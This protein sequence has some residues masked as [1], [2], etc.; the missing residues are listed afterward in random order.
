MNYVGVVLAILSI[1]AFVLVRPDTEKFFKNAPSDETQNKLDENLCLNTDK[2]KTN[3]LNNTNFFD[4]LNPTVKRIVGISLAIISGIFFGSVS[5]TTL[6]IMI[7]VENASKSGSDYTFS[8]FSGILLSSIFC[9]I[10]YS[11]IKKCKPI[12]YPK[13]VVPSFSGGLIW[14]NKS[15]Y[16][17]NSSFN[18][19]NFRQLLIYRNCKLVCL[20][21]P[22]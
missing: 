19:K 10:I 4:K 18:Y 11:M 6:Y 14:G 20:R 7:T 8:Y 17:K 21:S 3:N 12:L 22:W 9:F 13:A 16:Y 15:I 1:I 2:I 5:F